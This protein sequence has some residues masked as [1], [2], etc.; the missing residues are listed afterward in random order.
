MPPCLRVFQ[1]CVCFLKNVYCISYYTNIIAVADLTVNHCAKIQQLEVRVG[2]EPTVFR[3]CNPV[4]WATLPPHLILY[5]FTHSRYRQELIIRYSALI[6]SSMFKVR[7]R[8]ALPITLT[9][10]TKNPGVF[11]VQGP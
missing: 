8:L 2:V 5:H 6:N 3:I 1:Y 4:Q 10:K 9:T 7:Y 11:L